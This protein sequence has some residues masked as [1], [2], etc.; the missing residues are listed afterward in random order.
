MGAWGAGGFQ[1]DAALD[2]ADSISSVEQAEVTIRTPRPTWPDA[3]EAAAVIAAGE[4]VAA[5]FGRAP[6]DM[7]T[8]LLK[9]LSEARPPDRR[10]LS[11]ARNA[12]E[13]IANVS[14]LA[15]LWAEDDDADWREAIG[16]CFS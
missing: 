5:S 16:E 9:K 13:Q 3:D 1:N 7:P 12:V 8:E 6:A 11:D 15:D 10:L 2:Y 14:E 4:I